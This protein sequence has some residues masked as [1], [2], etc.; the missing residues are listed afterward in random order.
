M[1]GICAV[2]EQGGLAA[3]HQALTP[4]ARGLARSWSDRLDTLADDQAGVAASIGWST[5]QT[6]QDDVVLIACDADLNDAH[7]EASEPAG[8]LAKLYDQHGCD[9][10]HHLRGAFSVVIWDRRNRE[11]IAA[12]DPF[13]IKRL[14]YATRG[15]SVVVASR[16]DALTRAPGISSDI[17]P[18]AIATFLNFGLSLAPETIFRNIRRL[19]PG[20]L[21]R[22]SLGGLRIDRYWDMRYGVGAETDERRLC[23]E[24]EEVFERAVAANCRNDAFSQIG[25][26]LSGGTDSSTVVAMMSR[27]DRGPVQAFSIGFEEE[28]FN[29]LEYA[30]ITAA[31]F[32]AKHHIYRVTA[33]DCLKAI[34]NMIRYF[35]EPFANASAIPTYFC[36]RLA[37]QNGVQALLSGDGGDELFGGNE[38]YRTDKIF[39]LY[40]MLPKLL[41]KGAVEPALAVLPVRIARSYVRRSNLHPLER[42]FSYNFLREH[43]PEKVFHPDFRAALGEYSVLEAPARYYENAAAKDRLDRLLYVDIKITLGDSDLPKVTQMSELAGIQT[44]FPLLDLAVAE[45]SGR[46]PAGL[47]VK[48]LNKRYLFK[49]A[50]RNLLPSEVIRK[51]K[52]GFGIPVS[53]WLKSDRQLRELANDALRSTRFVERGYFR[54]GFVD[55]LFRSYALDDSSYYGDC[56]WSVLVLELWHR[57][58]V[59]APLAVSA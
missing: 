56:V 39:H 2:W 31:K 54:R 58:F 42:Y 34:P 59:D 19:P 23:G 26:Y 22:A 41:R 48:G 44:R 11:L 15:E 32:R 40:Q 33:E 51:K 18:R 30:Q 37:A 4:V 52:H 35:D 29:E 24:M 12:V 17:N 28:R 14:V 57:Q 55:E 49:R 25:A 43:A 16:L 3:L 27:L 21:L 45:F 20:C 36:A 5:Q 9:F 13:G 50:L 53:I 47:K 7:L 1:S 46:V 6:F 38:R 8:R 10:V